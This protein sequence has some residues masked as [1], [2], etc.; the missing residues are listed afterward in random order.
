MAVIGSRE[1]LGAAV[2]CVVQVV[3]G[4]RFPV[5]MGDRQLVMHGAT[6]LYTSDGRSGV[7]ARCNVVESLD[8]CVC[9][10]AGGLCRGLR[11]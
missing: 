1:T 4:C 10:K 7:E 6:L 8:E 3:Q 11:A 5:R 2:H 9:S